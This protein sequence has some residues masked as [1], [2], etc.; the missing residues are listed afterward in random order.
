MALKLYWRPTTSLVVILLFSLSICISANETQASTGRKNDQSVP[1]P[2]PDGETNGNSLLT[3]RRMQDPALDKQGLLAGPMFLGLASLLFPVLPVLLLAPLAVAGAGPAMNYLQDVFGTQGNQATGSQVGTQGSS[4]QA[5]NNFLNQLGSSSSN[6]DQSTSGSSVS[7]TIQSLVGN[8]NG[9]SPSGSSLSQVLSN[10]G[11]SSSSS[12]NQVG[13]GSSL[14][15]V[16][17]ALGLGSSGANEPEPQEGQGSGSLFSGSSSLLNSIFGPDRNSAGSSGLF[18]GSG[19]SG[20]F[21]GSGSSGLFSG[22]GSIFGNLGSGSRPV[23]AYASPNGNKVGQ[24][25]QSVGT[26]DIL[27]AAAAALDNAGLLGPIAG[28]G[29]GSVASQLMNLVKPGSSSGSSSSITSGLSELLGLGGDKA[30]QPQTSPLLGSSL[31]SNI[32]QGLTP[33]TYGQA[34]IMN[35][36]ANQAAAQAAAS[37]SLYGLLGGS[38][39]S[40]QG[41]VFNCVCDNIYIY[42]YV[43]SIYLYISVYNICIIQLIHSVFSV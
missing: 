41:R 14:S 27:G 38:S 28:A 23:P 15:Q 31:S 24:N 29:S 22:S 33:H 30:T 16:V 2:S 4:S 26:S 39:S 34:Q 20:L 42:L 36:M 37:P 7:Q 13:S 1:P 12:G 10:L 9:A 18:S 25:Q 11:S 40:N 17:Q 19:S 21:S 35:Q 8:A 32:V 5:I 43:I 3:P 6:N